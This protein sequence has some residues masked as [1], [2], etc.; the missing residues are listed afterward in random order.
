MRDLKRS[1]QNRMEFSDPV[2]GGKI[3][4]HYA[5]PTAT[6][7]KV[8]RQQ[9]ITRKNGK[10]I[11][12]NFDPA[13]RFGL[14][15]LTGFE[16]G[17]FGYDGQPISSDPASPNYRPDW[18]DLLKDTASDVVTLFAQSVFDGLRAGKAD[19]DLTFGEGEVAEEPVPLV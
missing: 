6:Q 2:G 18:K 13:L 19:E 4:L 5:T 7:V 16:E 1:D 10:V 14:E 9:S 8:Y 11:F 3:V 15:I 12:N 17:A